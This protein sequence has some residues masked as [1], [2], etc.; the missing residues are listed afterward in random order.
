MRDLDWIIKDN[1]AAWGRAIAKNL[2]K[3]KRQEPSLLLGL[4]L[5]SVTVAVV[6]ILLY[7]YFFTNSPK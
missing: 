3:E 5:A 6:S 4:V 2:G 1:E 7:L